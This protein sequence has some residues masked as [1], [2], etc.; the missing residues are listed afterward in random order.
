[1]HFVPADC[2]AVNSTLRFCMHS[3][4]KSRTNGHCKYPCNA[5]CTQHRYKCQVHESHFNLHV[6]KYTLARKIFGCELP[7]EVLVPC[8]FH[9]RQNCAAI[10]LKQLDRLFQHEI[11]DANIS[12]STKF[13]YCLRTE[14]KP[15]TLESLTPEDLERDGHVGSSPSDRRFTSGV[16]GIMQSIQQIAVAN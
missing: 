14:C 10:E 11:F 13:S 8:S 1:M 5:T 7:S 15:D 16:R 12:K 3:L 4:E 9:D 6:S 2:G